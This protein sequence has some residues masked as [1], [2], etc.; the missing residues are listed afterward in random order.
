MSSLEKF[1]SDFTSLFQ[2]ITAILY[3]ISCKNVD[4][5]SH[6]AADGHISLKATPTKYCGPKFEI[7]NQTWH[8]VSH[9][10]KKKLAILSSFTFFE[11]FRYCVVCPLKQH[12]IFWRRGS[13]LCETSKHTTA[14]FSTNVGSKKVAERLLK[15]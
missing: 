6:N 2:H 9:S 11:N 14:Q 15:R 12:L 7:F 4:I 10:T 8:V 5:S 1:K 3:R 13:T